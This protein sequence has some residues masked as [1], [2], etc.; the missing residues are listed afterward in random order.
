LRGAI[1]GAAISDFI[2]YF[3]GTDPTRPEDRRAE[4]GDERVPEMREFLTR[5]SPATNASR[6]RIPLL[7]VHG[8]ND[9]RV[10]VAQAE[11]MARRVRA[12]GFPVWT[13][14]YTDEGH[15]MPSKPQNI[16]LMLYAWIE[17]MKQFLLK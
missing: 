14:I 12:N 10:P 16:N 9:T 5:I 17:F 4:Y 1:A 8:A 3:E 15:S 6:L 2:T 13:I 7:I 11:E